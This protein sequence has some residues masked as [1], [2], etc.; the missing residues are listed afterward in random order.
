MLC[1]CVLY[2]CDGLYI[3]TVTG[4]DP[5]RDPLTFRLVNADN[6]PFKMT[7]NGSLF[8]NTSVYV[9]DYEYRNEYTLIDLTLLAVDSAGLSAMVNTTVEIIDINQGMFVSLCV[10]VRVGLRVSNGV[11]VDS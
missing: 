2:S 6:G 11:H 9:L 10:C 7:S 4:V 8:V 5:D 1:S 3:G